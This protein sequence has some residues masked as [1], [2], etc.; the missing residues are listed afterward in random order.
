MTN[1]R[2][3]RTKPS[4][5]IQQYLRTQIFSGELRPGEWIRLEDLANEFGVS[6][7]PVREAVAVLVD[8]GLLET[9][10]RKG[11]T[12][13]PFSLQDVRDMYAVYAVVYGMLT[14]KAAEHLSDD[15]LDRLEGLLRQIDMT[16][17]REELQ[18]LENEFHRRINRSANSRYLANMARYLSRNIPRVYFTRLKDW[19]ETAQ[20]LDYQVLDALRRRDARAAREIMER[21]T[22]IGGDLLVDYLVREGVFGAD[23]GAPAEPAVAAPAPPPGVARKRL[24]RAG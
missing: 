20:R 8:E 21:H 13:R 15:E 22:L 19:H 11:I 1:Q 16:A 18:R 6:T 3:E 2:F 12:V 4:D 7:T 5:A 10:T 9:R 14:E 23:E 17:D 24:R